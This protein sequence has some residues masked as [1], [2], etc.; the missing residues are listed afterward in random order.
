MLTVAVENIGDLAVV[1]C[2]G[3]IVRSEAAFKLRQ[4]VMS[5]QDAQIVVLDLTEVQAIEGGGLGML[6]FLQ[7]WTQD[8]GIQLKLFNPTGSVK[9]RLEHERSMPRFDIAT[10]DEMVAL[11]LQTDSPYAVA[12]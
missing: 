8:R 12:A 6:W 7:R 11:L 3:R 1:T 9:N 4:A 5:Q 10:F 2:K